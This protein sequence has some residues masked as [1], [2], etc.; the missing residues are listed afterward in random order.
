MN[1]TILKA[2]MNQSR[3]IK[4]IEK[5]TCEAN[6]RDYNAKRNLRAS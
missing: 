5:H 1:K 3:L 2:I 4:N 6:K